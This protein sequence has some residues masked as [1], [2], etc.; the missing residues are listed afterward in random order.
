MGAT[1]PVAMAAI[2]RL[3]PNAAEHSFSFL[4]LANVLGAIAGAMVPAFVLIE[5]FGFYGTLRVASVCNALLAAVVL[6]VSA[7]KTQEAKP[8]ARPAAAR[9]F[10]SSPSILWLLFTTGL[11]SMAMEVVWIRQF[12]VY[13]GNVVYAFA[14]ILAMYLVRHVH[15]LAHL[16][17]CGSKAV[18]AAWVALGLAGLLPLLFADPRLPLPEAQYTVEG[19]LYGALRAGLGVILFSGLA[20]FVTPMLVDRWSAGDPDRAGRAYAVN[21]AGSILGP[22]VSGFLV[23]PWVGEHWGLVLITLPLFAIGVA[24]A[25]RAPERRVLFAACAAG[26]LLLLAFS[27][28][29]G[30][31]FPHRVELR[32]YAATVIATGEGMDKR[33]L[34]NG[35]GM[36]VLTPITKV[37]AH[38]P[39]TLLGGLRNRRW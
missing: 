8:A 31:K 6:G 19:F 27:K 4:Y 5:L 37:M 10:D 16:P 35:T 18:E 32:D 28:D 33:L 12:T 2:R 9:A 26:S 20:G 36:T 23:L 29:Y 13:L 15:R 34:V 21:V 24:V 7:G 30:T 14:A 3:T 25:M 17:P 22:L 38:L 1:F 11:C 39:L